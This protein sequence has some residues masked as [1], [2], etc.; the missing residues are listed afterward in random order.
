MV[1]LSFCFV[2]GRLTAKHRR[3]IISAKK[4]WDEDY[5]I[6]CGYENPI[7]NMKRED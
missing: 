6:D 1:A 4:N 2:K 3:R 5:L 7:A